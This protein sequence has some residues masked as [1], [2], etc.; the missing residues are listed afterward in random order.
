MAE[1][2]LMVLIRRAAQVV[3]TV[4]LGRKDES[5]EILRQNLADDF[6]LAC[7]V[8][9]AVLLRRTPQELVD[10][11]ASGGDALYAER[12][13]ILSAVLTRLAAVQ[14][15][16]EATLTELQCR[17]LLSGLRERFGADAALVECVTAIEARLEGAEPELDRA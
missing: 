16:R 8:D 17:A 3:A 11:L 4:L 7:G 1:D 5:P 13:L 14:E 10:L 12:A 15:G 6:R 9:L 2:Y